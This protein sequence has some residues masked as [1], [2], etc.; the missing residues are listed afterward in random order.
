MI[1]FLVFIF[2]LTSCKTGWTTDEQIQFKNDCLAM[3]QGV[4]N[5]EK[6]CDC[7]LEKAMEKYKT[8]EEAEKSIQN[9]SDEEIQK[10]FA[11]CM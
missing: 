7:G 1:V 6:I 11:E 8:K 3:S 4:D 2:A 5:P 9:M 10:L